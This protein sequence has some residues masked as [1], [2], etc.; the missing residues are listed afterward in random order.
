MKS[1]RQSIYN[2][3]DSRALED[4]ER[5]YEEMRAE[6]ERIRREKMEET[7]R[8]LE[9]QQEEMEQKYRSHHELK[10]VYVD[11]KNEARKEAQEKK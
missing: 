10:S 3:L 11:P 1:E 7:E 2:P 4:H 9:M 6:K 5:K 8:L